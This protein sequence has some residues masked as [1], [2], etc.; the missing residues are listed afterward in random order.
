MDV[1]WA[2]VP[3]Q[4]KAKSLYYTIFKK[5]LHVSND[6]HIIDLKKQEHV[7]KFSPN[8]RGCFYTSITNM[9]RNLLPV[10]LSTLVPQ[11]ANF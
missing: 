7:K 6:S 1:S 11:K 4:N 5:N 3:V 9:A 8:L 10:N 2:L